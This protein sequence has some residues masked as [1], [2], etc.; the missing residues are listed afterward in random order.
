MEIDMIIK[1]AY[2][3]GMTILQKAGVADYQKD[4]FYLLEHV[5]GINRGKYYANQSH[6]IS[7]REWQE[8]LT[9]INQRKERIPLQHLIG[10]QEFMGLPFKVN[11]HVLIPRQDTE[12]LVE[13]TL[14]IIKN[15]DDIKRNNKVDEVGSDERDKS[16]KRDKA[17]D[18][19]RDIKVD[20]EELRILDMC[21]GS[22]CILIS[23]LCYA[24]K[25]TTN[26]KGVAVDISMEALEVAKENAILN[27]IDITTPDLTVDS[28][29]RDINSFKGS[30]TQITFLQSDLFTKLDG[31]YNIIVSNPPY[32]PTQEIETLEE[33]VKDH[34]PILALDGKEDG[35]YFY[36][37]IAKDSQKHLT[38][39]GVLIFECGW[40]QGEEV[41][42]IM[43]S[44]GFVETKII[45]DL[46]G[47]E[48]VVLGY[49]KG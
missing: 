14:E 30:G 15:I 29:N 40:N 31:R 43:E 42:Q 34:D 25:K 19:K 26:I 37:Q 1:E 38:E 3:F 9:L 20:D 5:T 6:K 47:Q 39:D 44:H 17:E 33:E 36:R 7:K 27:G 32:I 12:I 22:G 45:E 2:D 46:N 24:T 21:T 8:Y 23:I 35:L 4:S 13:T 28:E 11:S 41:S 16:N 49:I 48:R 10:T 18:D